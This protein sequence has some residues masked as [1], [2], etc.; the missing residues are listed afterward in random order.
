MSGKFSFSGPVDT[1]P[2]GIGGWLLWFLFG[3]GIWLLLSFIRIPAA[4]GALG[5]SHEAFLTGYSMARP[6]LIMEAAWSLVVFFGPAIGLYLSITK[7]RLTPR[8]W[9]VYLLTVGGYVA[10]D[11]GLGAALRS[12]MHAAIT[13]QS[14][15][16]RIDESMGRAELSNLKMLLW[17]GVWSLYWKKSLRV[18]NTF[19]SQAWDPIP[20]RKA[21]G[22]VAEY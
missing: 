15:I 11:I 9:A 10:L 14:V 21:E 3:Q 19:G 13:D 2:E 7:S 16:A 4:F 1:G 20:V 6:V 18:R 12:Q 17:V 8:F 5:P 22:S